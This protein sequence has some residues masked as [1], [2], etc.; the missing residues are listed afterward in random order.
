M[1]FIYTPF[2]PWLQLTV[3]VVVGLINLALFAVLV[4]DTADEPDLRHLTTID[5]YHSPVAIEHWANVFVSNNFAGRGLTFDQFMTNPRGW[6]QVMVFPADNWPDNPRP[7]LPAQNV[8]YERQLREDLEED[9]F[10]RMEER[11][12]E[13]LE[14]IYNTVSNRG[15]RVTSSMSTR[16]QPRKWQTRGQHLKPI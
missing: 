10:I 8:V 12:I 16:K 11:Q 5:D 7:L 15:G 4:P 6:L 1:D 9:E 2:P 14:H 3:I 13:E